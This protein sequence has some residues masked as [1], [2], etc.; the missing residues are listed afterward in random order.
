MESSNLREGLDQAT[1]LAEDGDFTQAVK[2]L[3]QLLAHDDTN[4]DALIQL[5]QCLAKLGRFDEATNALNKLAGI[6]PEN[7][8][9]FNLLVLRRI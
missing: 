3:H 2:Y 7:V 8:E 5:A 9:A 1:Q 6:Q 4:I